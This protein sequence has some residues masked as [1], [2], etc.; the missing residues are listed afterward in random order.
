MRPLFGI[1]DAVEPSFRPR[2]IEGEG[3]R[4][5]IGNRRPAQS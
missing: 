3:E 5:G 4:V 2:E 1:R